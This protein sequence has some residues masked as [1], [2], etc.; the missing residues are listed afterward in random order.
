MNEQ[1]KKVNKYI[2]ELNKKYCWANHKNLDKFY[3][4]NKKS[5][6][7]M[8]QIYKDVEPSF[9]LQFGIILPIDNPFDKNEFSTFKI[10][11]DDN[12]I[13]FSFHFDML[14]EKSFF[15]I[16]KP[17]KY[18]KAFE[19]YRTRCEISIVMKSPKIEIDGQFYDIE[20]EMKNV[21]QAKLKN[22][23]D[24]ASFLTTTQRV[25]TIQKYLQQI[26]IDDLNEVLL[27]Y[28]FIS[29]DENICSINRDNIEFASHFRG[30]SITNWE[31]YNWMTVHNVQA[32]PREHS[33]NFNKEIFGHSLLNRLDRNLFYEFKRNLQDSRYLFAKGSTIESLIKMNTSI[34][35][36]LTQILVLY[37]TNEENLKIDD[38][39]KK[40]DDIPFKK[41][42]TVELPKIL[43]G[44]W[45]ITKKGKP[46]FDWYWNSYS[47]RNKI[48]HGGYMPEMK[49]V[50]NSQSCC[51]KFINYVIDLMNKSKFKYLHGLNHVEK[52]EI[53]T[54]KI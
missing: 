41:R 53:Q 17:L 29:E 9:I 20:K 42:I 25:F 5:Y 19:T 52:L 11:E 18:R 23:D 36:L 4:L 27:N 22:E 39:I 21:K 37:W 2:N 45:D 38:I 8:K 49:E 13:G 15:Y 34:E 6:Q 44:T 35:V 26:A 46:L 33:S 31:T 30:I 28:A 1:N 14:K 50:N 43:G 40:L 51:Y 54:I 16:G 48:V 7:H 32:Y 24:L 47:L 10:F 3:C 12:K